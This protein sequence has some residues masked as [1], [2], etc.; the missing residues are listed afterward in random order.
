[1]H[2][3]YGR[4]RVLTESRTIGWKASANDKRTHLLRPDP[5]CEPAHKIPI[6]IFKPTSRQVARPIRLRLMSNLT[7]RRFSVSLRI[8]SGKGLLHTNTEIIDACGF[9][10]SSQ[11][12]PFFYENI[13]SK[14]MSLSLIGI[15]RLRDGPRYNAGLA[16][17][18]HI[19]R[20]ILL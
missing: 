2:R 12:A 19:C 17:R 5:R 9:D 15:T 14:I 20:E 4:L 6:V 7:K 16:S 18:S 3:A 10:A 13:R 1:M 8:C 11:M